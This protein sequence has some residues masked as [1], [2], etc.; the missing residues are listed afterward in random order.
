MTT[1]NG[2]AIQ[3]IAVSKNEEDECE[4]WCL[5]DEA[6]E[7]LSKLKGPIRL[8]VFVGNYREG[9]SYAAGR[10]VGDLNQFAFSNSSAAKTKGIRMS[11][12]PMKDSNNNCY[13]VIDT[14]GLNDTQSTLSLNAYIMSLSILFSCKVIYNFK[15]AITSDNLDRFA[16][17]ICTVKELLKKQQATPNATS[18]LTE[19]KPELLWLLRDHTLE[20]RDSKENVL[21]PNEYL[22]HSLAGSKNGL[23]L[24]DELDAL[25]SKRE[26]VT[27]PLPAANAKDLVDMKNNNLQFENALSTLI[28]YVKH[29]PPKMVDGAEMTGPVLISMAD[30]FC[31]ILSRGDVPQLLTVSENI[32]MV[33]LK[34]AV[35]YELDRFKAVM[36]DLS[37]PEPKL[38]FWGMDTMYD[39]T[40]RVAKSAAKTAIFK[41][42]GAT[43]M[44][45]LK[46]LEWVRNMSR[47]KAQRWAENVEA[48]GTDML[49][50]MPETM[51]PIWKSLSEKLA[52]MEDLVAERTRER[53]E[54][55]KTLEYSQSLQSSASEVAG[56]TLD[57]TEV[58]ALKTENARLNQEVDVLKMMDAQFQKRIDTSITK[59]KSDLVVKQEALATAEQRLVDLES[60]LK[61]SRERVEDCLA[62]MA[63]FDQE[64][65]ITTQEIKQLSATAAL[66]SHK[67][68]LAEN[69]LNGERA[70]A[71]EAGTQVK[72]LKSEHATQVAALRAQLT[73]A[74]L[75][76]KTLKMAHMFPI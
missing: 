31:K 40:E 34:E 26:L 17:A 70:K 76:L 56:P 14:E 19:S 52:T 41:E 60:D 67:R 69:H 72:R 33:R 18:L 38:V 23:A 58:E 45:L 4:Q 32:R 54:L 1:E 68:Q 62:K 29:T 64:R 74:E 10:F 13:Y 36:N 20:L 47:M 25:F 3:L 65:S 27:L 11:T 28:Q 9:K 53:D 71:N 51:R 48:A 2:T 57:E 55:Q 44:L 50:L 39:E 8:I 49:H 42:A 75:D 66:E 37:T 7:F 16:S 61:T 21:S 73:S 6:R 30:T 22:E 12:K 5:P 35:D 43:R 46:C 15:H 59:L 63:T 24:R